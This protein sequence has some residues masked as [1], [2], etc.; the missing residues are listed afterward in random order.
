VHLTHG[1]VVHTT[2]PL[3]QPEVNSC[4]HREY[5][6]RYHDVVEVRYDKVGVVILEVRRC[7]RQHQASESTDG[8]KH[9]EADRKQHGRFESHRATP[10]S[11]YPVKYLHACRHRD[12]HGRV[13]K[14]QLT[15]H[16]HTHGVHVVGP[17]NE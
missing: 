2:R 3:R 8:E 15:G 11:G 16:R 6:T 10:H 13:H 12:Q 1:F 17:N 7:N 9:K 4:R 5:R 14:E